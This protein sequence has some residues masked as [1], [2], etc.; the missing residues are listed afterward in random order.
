[1]FK[2]VD[3]NLAN[4]DYRIF[5]NSCGDGAFLCVA[6]EMK[7]KKI[8]GND[9]DA[10]KKFVQSLSSVYG[11]DIQEKNVIILRDKFFNIFE[12][13]FIKKFKKKS[14]SSFNSIH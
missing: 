2:L 3:A 4:P 9:I 5:D 11:I 1:M 8:R 12:K 7:L 13:M 14:I 10:W 6:L